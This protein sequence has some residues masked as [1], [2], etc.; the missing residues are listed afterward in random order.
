[1][2]GTA[3][4]PRGPVGLTFCLAVTLPLLLLSACAEG[5]FASPPATPKRTFQAPGAGVSL[6]L[7]LLERSIAGAVNGAREQHGLKP[8]AW[9]AD[10]LPVSRGHSEDMATQAFYDHLNRRGEDADRRAIRQGV[11]CTTA[12]PRLKGIGENLSALYW[13]ASYEMTYQGGASS[14]NFA[15]LTPQAIPSRVVSSWMGSPA[16]RSNVLDASYKTQ[17]IGIAL[18]A[19]YQLFI[20][21]NLC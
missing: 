2:S 1:M 11:P 8:L 18:S 9:N 15:W 3:R 10:L 19:D 4:R 12:F 20:T 16:H 7:D 13:Y 6:N 17:A 21:Q 14:V 5:R